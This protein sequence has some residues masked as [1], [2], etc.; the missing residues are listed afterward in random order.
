MKCLRQWNFPPLM[1]KVTDWGWGILCM[2]V[3]PLED[4]RCVKSASQGNH[5]LLAM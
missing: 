1:G 4:V 3:G 5:D 2:T